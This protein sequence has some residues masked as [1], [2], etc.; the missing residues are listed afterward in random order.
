MLRG[1]GNLKKGFSKKVKADIK[2][3]GFNL[4]FAKGL[5]FKSLLENILNVPHNTATLNYL[6]DLYYDRYLAKDTLPMQIVKDSNKFYKSQAWKD[7]RKL[8][9]KVFGRQYLCCGSKKNLHI[10]HVI[11]RSVSPE[12]ALKVKNLQPLC[13]ECNLLKGVSTIDYRDGSLHKDRKENLEVMRLLLR[14]D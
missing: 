8:V 7:V 1:K 5:N 12:L 11:P 13:E 9:F 2:L 14:N 6:L 4:P 3:R 10:D